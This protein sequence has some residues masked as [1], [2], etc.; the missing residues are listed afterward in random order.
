MIAC[1]SSGVFTPQSAS[2]VY[3]LKGMLNNFPRKFAFT[4][5]TNPL[6]AAKRFTYCQT[7]SSDV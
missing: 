6:K 1:A 5:L 2:N 7:S 3:I 4:R